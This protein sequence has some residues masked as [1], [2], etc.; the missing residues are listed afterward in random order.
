M[1]CRRGQREQPATRAIHDHETIVDHLP[2]T[3]GCVLS[4][5][6]AAISS[7]AS[8]TMLACCTLLL[9]C[10]ALLPAAPAA[11]P[12]MR[13]NRDEGGGYYLQSLMPRKGLMQS[14]TGQASER[15]NTGIVPVVASAVVPAALASPAD[16]PA[17]AG[18]ASFAP[19]SAA[20]AP[21]P[22]C[23]AGSGAAEEAGGSRSCASSS[24]WAAAAACSTPHA[25]AK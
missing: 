14:P 19:P 16:V 1:G 12:A 8:A 9:P 20:A 22:P 13:G 23:C 7:R 2:R 24:G 10:A 15:R 17:G 5:G 21:A 4:S 6:A 25:A 11:A 3:S 18:R